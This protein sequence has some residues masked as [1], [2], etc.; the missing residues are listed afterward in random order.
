M[1]LR[2]F[3][4]IHLCLF[5]SGSRSVGSALK[6]VVHCV[7]AQDQQNRFPSRQSQLDKA[8][9]STDFCDTR[10][11]KSSNLERNSFKIGDLFALL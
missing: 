2:R 9:G 5:R 10:A 1:R 7:R 4:A 6:A 8:L 3:A 11:I